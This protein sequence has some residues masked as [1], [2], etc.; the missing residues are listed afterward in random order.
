M[1]INPQMVVSSSISSETPFSLLY[2]PTIVVEEDG[3]RGFADTKIAWVAA[4]FLSHFHAI[5]NKLSEMSPVV[6]LI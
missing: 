6:H 4:I 2:F 3:K 5:E 1:K